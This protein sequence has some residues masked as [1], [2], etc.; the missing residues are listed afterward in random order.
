M[1]QSTPSL[2]AWAIHGRVTVRSAVLGP[3]HLLL[4]L[5]TLVLLAGCGGN[6][7]EAAFT[8]FVAV[9]DAG[10]SGSRLVLY[11]RIRDGQG[12]KVEQRLTDTG[13][14]ALSSFESNPQQ[15]GPAGVQPLIDKLQQALKTLNTPNSAVELHLL[16]TAGMRLV[17]ARNPAAAQAIYESARSVI[18]ASGLKPGRIET[19]SGTDE[20]LFA[21]LD[22]NDLA[23]HFRNGTPPALGIVEVGGASAQIAFATTEDYRPGVSVS[24]QGK[25]YRVFSQSWLGLG[26][27]Q[28][29]L[30]MIRLHQRQTTADDAGNP[31]Y[32]NN[33]SQIGGLTAFDAGIEGVFI[34]L[35]DFNF[36][37]CQSLYD[38][39]L[40]P[41][42]VG[43]VVAVPGFDNVSL[44]GV[45][46]VNFALQ[47]WQASAAPGMLAVQLQARCTGPDAYGAQ[48]LPYLGRNPPGNRFA[49]NAC[50]NGTYAHALLFGPQG[51]KLRPA[52]LQSES[53]A[54]VSVNWTRGVA[55]AGT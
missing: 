30:S 51:L 43:A 4:L 32:A 41:F 34:A 20:G 1:R 29:R 53:A 38:A 16:A 9:I 54:G 48:V 10:S 50:A 55:L 23:G 13:G 40:S 18:S 17:E 33:T 28:A 8:R 47:D 6:A 42:G 14:Q 15:A 21:W 35:G 26:Q 25:T 45:S 11:E 49:Q 44:V 37:A 46:S 7:G 52:Q 36:Q 3:V 39:V 19:L 22:L 5:L 12:I 27:D 24:V 2:L 31:C